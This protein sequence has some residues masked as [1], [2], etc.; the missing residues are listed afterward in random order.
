[1]PKLWSGSGKL[2]VRL[3]RWRRILFAFGFIDRWRPFNR[4]IVNAIRT[5]SVAIR[6]LTSRTPTNGRIFGGRII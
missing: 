6:I 3:R 1:M 5:I 2:R 4:R